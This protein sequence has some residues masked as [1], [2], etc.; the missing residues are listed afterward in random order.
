MLFLYTMDNFPVNLAYAKTGFFSKIIVDYLE[1]S[2][3]LLP[4]Y[5][6]NPSVQGIKEIVDSR[7]QFKTDRKRL[8]SCL[9]EQYKNLS[10]SVATIANIESLLQEN[11]FTVTT[12]HQNNIFTGPLYFIYKILHVIKLADSFTTLYSG[13]NFVPVF[14]MGS[15]DA[16]LKELNHIQVDGEKLVWNTRQQGAVGRMK[17][18]DELLGLIDILEAQVGVLPYGGELIQLFRE[19]YAK[20]RPIDQAT[21]QLV[22]ELF[23]EYGLV[24]ILPDNPVLKAAMLSVFE[25][26]LLHQRSAGIV[27]DTGKKLVNAGY[28]MQAH[29]R[30]I[31]LFYLQANSRE[32]IEAAG[33]V[34]HIVDTTKTFTRKEILQELH[35]HPENFS[36]NVILRGLYQATVLPDVAFVG[37]GGELAYWLQLKELFAHYKV[38][39]PALIL[40]NSFLL[41]TE[42]QQEKVSRYAIS[43]EEFFLPVEK[44]MNTLVTRESPHA[45]ALDDLL[46]NT[47][48]IYEKIKEKVSPVDMTLLQ[49]VNALQH[50]AVGKLQ[51][52]EK[53]MLKAEKRKYRDLKNGVAAIKAE[54][55]PH[56]SLQE[57]TDNIAYFYS[58]LG[59][60]FI[61]QLHQYSNTIEQQFQIAVVR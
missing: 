3:A 12:A 15:E 8:V 61:Q 40:R 32:R 54:L 10:P 37:G 29:A 42:R 51:E 13:Y 46:M 21:F 47:R 49:H 30:D 6:S 9:K 43:I 5:Q 2:D 16:D 48:Q 11:T 18:D 20:D 35:T 33:D 24:V 28:K 34:Y 19:A 31:N 45:L 39:Y 27:Q 57:R 23:K 50:K 22:N 52:L 14:W 55:F 59:K 17:V 56:G 41:L 58:L 53:K 4:F 36:P 44:L 7:G 60:D 25:D 38:P 1:Q 26:E